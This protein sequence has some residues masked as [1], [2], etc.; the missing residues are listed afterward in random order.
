MKLQRLL[1]AF[2]S[3][4]LL[5]VLFQL[6]NAQDP[7]QYGRHYD[8]VPYTK[9]IDIYQVNIRAF[10]PGSNLAG[11]T[12]RLNNIKNLG[13]NVVYLMPLYPV[14]TDAKSSNSPYCI[15]D[16]TSVG[17]EYGT[18]ADLRALVEGAHRKG[19]SVILDWVANQTSWDHPWITQHPDWYIR[20]ANGV[21]QQLDSYTDV[22]ALDMNNPEVQQAMV[23]AM[24]YWIFAAN[25]DGFRCDYADHA[26]VSFWKKTID[27]L[28]SIHSHK[29]IM[30]AEGS[31]PENFTAGFDMNF[32][33][34]FYGD[35]LVPIHNGSGVSK[36]QTANDQEYVDANPSQEV[37][38]YTGN[39]DTNGNG[40]P[41]EV[42]GGSAGVMANFVVAAY[43]K[44]VPFLYNGQ[45]VAF[46][47]RIPF[48]WTAVDIDWTQN[49]GVTKEFKKVLDFR[50]LSKA[51]RRGELL[52][53]SDLNVCAFTKSSGQ[54]EVLVFSN[55]RSTI[56]KY[57]IPKALTGSYKDAFTGATKKLKGLDTLFLNGFQYLVLTDRYDPESRRIS[58]SPLNS[59]IPVGTTLQITATL[60]PPDTKKSVQWSSDNP[61]IAS[62]D[63][64]GLVTAVSLGTVTITAALDNRNK[65][66]AAVTVVPQHNYTVHFFKPADWG[67]GINIY[68]YNVD[69]DGSLP[70]LNWPGTPMTND[71][72]GWYSYSFT[73][74]NSAIVIF[75]DGSKQSADL[76]RSTTGW[77]LNGVWYDTKP[78]TSTTFTVNFYR[79]ANWGTG[80]NIYWYNAVPDGSLPSPSWPGVPMTNHGDGWY[81][82][83]FTGATAATV[84]F[85]DGSNQSADLPRD[86]DGWYMDGVWYDTKPATPDVLLTVNFFRPSGWGTGI[87]IYWYNV[88][89]TG[90]LPSPSWPGVPMTDNGDGWYSYTF[91]NIA[92]AVVIF[93]DGT[94][95]SAD[96]PRDKSGWY[97][98]GIWH[99]TK[100]A[101]PVTVAAIRDSAGKISGVTAENG[102]ASDKISLTKIFPNPASGNYFNVYIPGLK[103]N[104]RASVAVL[105]ANGRTVLKTQISQSGNIRYNLKT[106]VYYVMINANGIHVTKKLVVE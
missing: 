8:Q 63:T 94:N 49:A 15:K 25:V 62:V 38:R 27:N 36:I 30:L 14:G 70:N 39:H 69:P 41:L 66:T 85:N 52:N 97:M 65:A 29:M 91:T 77:Y 74:V 45:E 31:R 56:S 64:N 103:N 13:M 33:F 100:P 88:Q 21:I 51:I 24:R 19:M 7:V 32:G 35:A 54:Q 102:A 96:L 37:A 9:D 86:K 98:D 99:D 47:K 42:F 53:Y 89:P 106:G 60:T 3:P 43:M 75:N 46:D 17:A 80:I 58:V 11:V 50:N 73:N 59:S 12:A 4:L 76:L 71:G 55:L 92:S 6:A 87:N 48:P 81:S 18:L 2:L 5:L 68:W 72:D 104:E 84:I 44:G 40:T 90:S 57:I 20:D 10:S 67:S 1:R 61:G 101:T 16:F 83:T 34:R 78:A 93:N 23:K 105:D 95:Q 26:P 82:F 28:R 22:A 79:P